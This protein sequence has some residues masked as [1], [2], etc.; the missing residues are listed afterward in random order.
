FGDVSAPNRMLAEAWERV[1]EG[2]LRF[3][4]ALACTSYANLMAAVVGSNVIGI[5]LHRRNVPGTVIDPDTG[6]PV[7]LGDWTLRWTNIASTQLILDPANTHPDLRDHD[8]VAVR[9]YYTVRR[10]SEL[11][12]VRIDAEK[13]RTLGELAQTEINASIASDGIVFGEYARM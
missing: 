3:I 11:F 13:A 10:A 1:L 4:K 2:D 7:M 9:Q 12:G 8:E 5:E 6:R